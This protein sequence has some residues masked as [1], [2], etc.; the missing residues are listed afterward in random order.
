M[1]I[2]NEISN[3]E[4]EV[5]LMPYT[6][7]YKLK[8]YPEHEENFKDEHSMEN[9]AIIWLDDPETIEYVHYFYYDR[10]YTPTWI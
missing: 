3:P 2:E 8:G 1:S 10:E 7:I 6:I 4:S 5:V 9:H